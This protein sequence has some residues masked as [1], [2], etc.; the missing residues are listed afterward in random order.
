MSEMSTG[1]ALRVSS[2]TFY[3]GRGDPHFFDPDPDPAF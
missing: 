3:Q 2:A 1:T